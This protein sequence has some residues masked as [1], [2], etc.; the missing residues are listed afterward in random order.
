MLDAGGLVALPTETVY[1]LAGDAA[2]GEAV[3]RIFAAKGRPRFNPLICHVTRPR[4]GAALRRDRRTRAQRLARGIL[5]GAA[6]A[7]RAAR[8]G[9]AGASAGDERASERR[10]PRAARGSRREVIAALRRR[11]SRRPR[12]TAPAGSARRR[13]EHVAA[14]LGDDVAADPRW[15]DTA[16]SGWNRPSSRS[17]A[18]G[19]GCSGPAGSTAE[20][21]EA[22]LG[23]PLERGVRTRARASS[24]RA[25][26]QAITRRACR[27][28]STRARRRAGEALLALRRTAGR[29]AR[30]A[31]AALEPQPIRRP[32]R[33]GGKPLR[34]SRPARP[35][36]RDGDRRRAGA[37]RR[38]GRGDQ[39]P[40]EAGRRAAR[41]ERRSRA[42]PP[43]PGPPNRNIDT[44]SSSTFTFARHFAV[45]RRE[46][47]KDSLYSGAISGSFARGVQK[48]A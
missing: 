4:H 5:A 45:R 18:R 20:A 3:A 9:R 26:W 46:I 16:R 1:G 11:R 35:E 29:R 33:G 17:S 25:C 10:A 7:R 42:T 21:I 31:V 13:A 32:R 12:P 19:R 41:V 23:T 38:T 34:A 44:S 36:R 48:S 40:A 28:G 47:G 22:V 15:R 6:D 37:A 24:H 39:R 30:Q 8:A 14:Q 43:R 27:C 2:N